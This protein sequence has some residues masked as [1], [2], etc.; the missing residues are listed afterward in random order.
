MIP[1]WQWYYRN[2]SIVGFFDKV[3]RYSPAFPAGE[4]G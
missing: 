1:A 2:T 3:L 4:I